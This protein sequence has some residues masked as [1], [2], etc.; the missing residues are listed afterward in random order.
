[1]AI[2]EIEG[3]TKHFRTGFFGRRVKAL[4]DLNLQVEAGE[5]FGFLG[6]N[7]AGKTTTI[8]T[9]LRLI[10]PTRGTARIHGFPIEDDAARRRTGYMPENAYFYRFLT[11]KEFLNFYGRLNGM[12]AGDRAKRTAELLRMV[13][14]EHAADV[15]IA[16]YSKGMTQRIG[17]AQSILTDPDLI[18]MDEP[19]SGVD[20]LG[21]AEMRDQI[22]NLRDKGKTI[23]FC[24]HILADVEALCERVAILDKGRLLEV[25]SISDLIQGGRSRFDLR[26]QNVNTET[27]KDLKTLAQGVRE[28]GGILHLTVDDPAQVA[29][30]L[31][32]IHGS[33]ARVLSIQER[34]ENLE[35][36]FVRLIGEAKAN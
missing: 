36:Y 27:I 20:P 23:F 21:R 25:G 26:I 32:K 7:G 35:S 11:G 9:L 16:E 5:I 18:L 13:G 34:R 30:V 24:S 28:R 12:G 8:K 33:K 6:P 2:L 22:L 14:L 10:F 4:E 3:L 29:A 31:D 1:M 19:L 15:R 17:L